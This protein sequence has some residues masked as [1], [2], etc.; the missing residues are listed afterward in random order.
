M[1]K[2][3]NSNEGFSWENYYRLHEHA[4]HSR[5]L[6]IAVKKYLTEKSAALDVGAGNLR[7]TKYLLEQ[8]FT[9]TALDPDPMSIKRAEELHHPLLQAV[10]EVVGKWNAPDNH[11]SLI[12]AQGILFHFPPERFRHVMQK[13]YKALKTGGVL[14]AE[15]L[16]TNDTW[17]H[18]NTEMTFLTK[19]ELIAILEDYEIEVLDELERDGTS[20]A[21]QIDGKDELK[22]WHVFK[23]IAVK[24]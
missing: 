2:S 5:H 20:A 16:G 10:Q 6:E 8:G 3:P 12:N 13:L 19:E 24:K 18:S 7:D 14:C 22:H 4:P 1:E 15:F 17:N 23:V 9:V 11:F 21:S